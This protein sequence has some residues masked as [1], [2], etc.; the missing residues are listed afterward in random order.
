MFRAKK[1]ERKQCRKIMH[2][3]KFLLVMRCRTDHNFERVK[4]FLVFLSACI[5]ISE[6]T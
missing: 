5:S 3:F 4:A 6:H 2:L 1:K